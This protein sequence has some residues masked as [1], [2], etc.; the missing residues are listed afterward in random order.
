MVLY[1]TRQ[2][3]SR[4]V[5]LIFGLVEPPLLRNSPVKCKKKVVWGESNSRKKRKCSNTIEIKV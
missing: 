5:L 2:R 3:N 4:L 1:H